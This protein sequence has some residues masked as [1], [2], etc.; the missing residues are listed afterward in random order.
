MNTEAMRQQG[1]TEEA[2][3]CLNKWNR[4]V[5]RAIEVT[6]LLLGLQNM[7]DGG[8]WAVLQS[9]SYSRNQCPWECG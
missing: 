6:T 3:I 8:N 2:S 7:H 5:V 4:K 1:R 9:F